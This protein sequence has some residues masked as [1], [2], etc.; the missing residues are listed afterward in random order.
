MVSLCT[1]CGSPAH[2][3]SCPITQENVEEDL[4]RIVD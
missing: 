4:F 1:L 2:I 3:R